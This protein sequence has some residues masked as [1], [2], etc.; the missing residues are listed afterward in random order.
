MSAPASSSAKS[1]EDVMQLRLHVGGSFAGELPHVYV[2]FAFGSTM[3]A[4]IE[5]VYVTTM[6]AS[7]TQHMY[8]LFGSA[9]RIRRACGQRGHQLALQRRSC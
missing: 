3:N 8:R 1:D 4:D 5:P 2:S 6:M 9:L 7:A